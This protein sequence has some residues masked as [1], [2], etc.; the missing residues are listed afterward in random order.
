[1]TPPPRSCSE[2]REYVNTLV[3]QDLLAEPEWAHVLT[4]EDRRGLTQLF[5][6]HVLP[7]ARSNST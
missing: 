7:T 6:T 4:D 2:F 1:M 3:I 5:W